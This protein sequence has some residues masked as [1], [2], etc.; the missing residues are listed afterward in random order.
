MNPGKLDRRITL[1]TASASVGV[2]GQ[3]TETWSDL[4][5]VWAMKRDTGGSERNQ[6]AQEFAKVMTIFTI[7]HRA[8][9]AA[10]GRVAYGG[11][12]YDIQFTKELGRS[13]F[14]ELHT[15][16]RADG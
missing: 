3:P 8:D 9:I 2:T 15:E 1:R 10:K 7:R 6:D 16:G 13:E 12:E 5:T 4:A 11:R 14:L